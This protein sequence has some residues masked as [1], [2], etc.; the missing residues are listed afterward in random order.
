[1]LAVALA[2]AGYVES[3]PLSATAPKA[4]LPG[5]VRVADAPKKAAFGV[6]LELP[7]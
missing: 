6:R 5:A 2:Q 1:M 7:E 4:A 3:A